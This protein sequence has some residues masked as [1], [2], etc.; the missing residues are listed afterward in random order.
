MLV[1]DAL[2]ARNMSLYG[3]PR[4]TTPNIDEF[5]RRAIIYRDHY[6]AGSHT[7]TGTASLLTG[8]YPWTHRAI[9]LSSNVLDRYSKNS[10]F[11]AISPEYTRFAF[12]QNLFAE[13][14][15]DQFLGAVD[16]HPSPGS[17]GLVQ[18]L[19]GDKIYDPVARYRAFEFFLSAD[20]PASLLFGAYNRYKAYQIDQSLQSDEF[21]YGLPQAYDMPI[22]FKLDDVFNGLTDCLVQLPQPFFAYLHVY[23]PHDPYYPRRDFTELFYDDWESPQKVN[24]RL[25]DREQKKVIDETRRLYDQYLAYTDWGFG[26]FYRALM[27]SG[28]LDNSYMIITSDH[29]EMF[30]RGVSGHVNPLMY[31]ALLQTPLIISCPGQTQGKDISANVSSIDLMPTIASLTGNPIPKW[32]EGMVLPGLGGA[33][34]HNRSIYSFEAKA[35]PT[36]GKLSPTSTMLRKGDYKLIY[37]I[38]YRDYK[39]YQK[40]P[41]YETGVFE[42]YNIRND[43][44]EMTDLISIEKEVAAALIKELLD[45][46]EWTTKPIS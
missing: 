12:T 19:M 6:S 34:N 9:R 17:F 24:H 7:S 4:R 11:H 1:F 33:E 5:A 2:S 25:G 22:Y 14:L 3:Y 42:L 35:S 38:G 13:L 43:P 44:E 30:E 39:G 27:E 37:Y 46:H 20:D 21:P 15:I 23:P 41:R 29:G 16:V 18:R 8:L 26:V 31:E 28:L 45:N 10:I 32:A 40:E 36:F